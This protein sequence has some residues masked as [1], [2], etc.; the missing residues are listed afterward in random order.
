MSWPELLQNIMPRRDMCYSK[1]TQWTQQDITLHKNKLSNTTQYKS[2]AYFDESGY[3][4]S[5]TYYRVSLTNSVMKNLM[6]Q[7]KLL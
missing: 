1:D 5:R 3:H 6:A 7:L 2:I 4:S